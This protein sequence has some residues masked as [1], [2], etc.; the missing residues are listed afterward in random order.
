MPSEMRGRAGSHLRRKTNDRT[1]QNKIK[2]EPPLPCS[3]KCG[4]DASKNR[5][6]GLCE[7]CGKI[8]ERAGK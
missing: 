6:D 1:I 3:R 7:N 5:K 2:N 8:H 4:R